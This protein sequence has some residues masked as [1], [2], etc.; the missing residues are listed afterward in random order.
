MNEDRFDLEEGSPEIVKD[1]A[2]FS[3][4]DDVDRF[5][6]AIGVTYR[7]NEELRLVEK[8]RRRDAHRWELDPASSDDYCERNPVKDS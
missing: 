2:A 3:D 1:S 6:E 4:Q 8:E 5:G 7:D